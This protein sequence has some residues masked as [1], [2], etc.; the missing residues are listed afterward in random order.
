MT[1]SKA[2]AERVIAAIKS[3]PY[4]TKRWLC[5]RLRITSGQ[6]QAATPYIKA[7]CERVNLEWFMKVAAP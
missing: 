6:F 7:E 2:T 3:N 5:D 4:E 1:P